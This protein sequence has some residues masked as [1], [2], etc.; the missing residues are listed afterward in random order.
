MF[1]PRISM[2]RPQVYTCPLHLESPSHLLPDAVD[3]LFVC[4]SWCAPLGQRSF[5]I[6]TESKSGQSFMQFRMDSL[7]YGNI[8]NAVIKYQFYCPLII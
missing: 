2:N 3:F 4:L 5:L 8:H 6:C 7:F 1:L